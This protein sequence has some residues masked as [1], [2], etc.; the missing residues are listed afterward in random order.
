MHY[1]KLDISS[2]SSI[3]SFFIGVKSIDVLINNAGINN[4]NQETPD[5]A[6]Q[7]IEVNYKGTRDMCFAFLSKNEKTSGAHSRIVN[8]S[9]TACQLSNY[10]PYIAEEFSTINS[11]ARIDALA[12]KY[13]ETVKAGASAQ[14]NAGFGRPPKSYQVS[15]ALT[16]ALTIVLARENQHVA[17]NCCCPGWVNTDMGHQV[18]KPPKT[19]E[20][21]AR[22]PVRLAIGELGPRGDNDGGLDRESRDIISG[23]YFGNERVT[24]RGWGQVRKW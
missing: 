6:E 13:V 24:D 7:V 12:D 16:N 14:E 23:R 11:V 4:N 5:L 15:K 3:N 19:L 2:P 9:S 22:I 10:S 17:I 1:S 18:G 21:G 20:E 8:V